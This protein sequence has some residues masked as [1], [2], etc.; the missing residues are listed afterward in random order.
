MSKMYETTIAVLEDMHGKPLE[1]QG[2]IERRFWNAV[3]KINVPDK[4]SGVARVEAHRFRPPYGEKI[5]IYFGDDIESVDDWEC[6]LSLRSLAFIPHGW[7]NKNRILIRGD[8]ASYVLAEKNGVEI[9]T[10]FLEDVV[11]GKW[12]WGIP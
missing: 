11:S 2:E 12:W 8:W 3:E 5:G 10:D 6:E 1:D 9:M 4:V 7:W